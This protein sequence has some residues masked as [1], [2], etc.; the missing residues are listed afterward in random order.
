MKFIGYTYFPYINGEMVINIFQTS[1]GNNILQKDVFHSS[2]ITHAVH[3]LMIVHVSASI[4]HTISLLILNSVSYSNHI[5]F[6]L[7]SSQAVIFFMYN[8]MQITRVQLRMYHYLLYPL[9]S[10]YNTYS[11]VQQVS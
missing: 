4:L 2:F 6:P 9:S 7:N 3:G 1:Q 5:L 8:M 11:K 10:V